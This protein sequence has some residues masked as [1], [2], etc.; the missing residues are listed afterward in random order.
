MNKLTAAEII[1][2]LQTFEGNNEVYNTKWGDSFL[3]AYG[4]GDYS[5]E[6]VE[7]ELGPIEE[8]DSYGGEG[9][10]DTYYVINYFKDHNVYIK[11]SGWYSSGNGVSFHYGWGSEVFPK[12]KTVTVYE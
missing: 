2:K 6:I 3:E 5:K 10:G 9:Q 7:K 1:E 4:Q 12:Q 11:T 8:A